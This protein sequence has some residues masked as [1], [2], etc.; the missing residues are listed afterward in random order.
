MSRRKLIK[1][2]KGLGA[3]PYHNCDCPKW[4]EDILIWFAVGCAV[5]TFIVCVVMIDL[6]IHKAWGWLWAYLKSGIDL[7]KQM[8]GTT[9]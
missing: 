9:G 5:F 7:W 6:A 1:A 4:A 2:N 8:L 3:N